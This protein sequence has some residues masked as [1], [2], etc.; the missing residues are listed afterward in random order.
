[1][2]LLAP[3]LVAAALALAPGVPAWSGVVHLVA[4]PPL[5][6]FADLRLLLSWAPSHWAFWSLAVA[7]L[8]ARIAILALLLPAGDGPSRIRFALVYYVVAWPF[9]LLAAQTSFVAHAALYSRL[10]WAA[11]VLTGA[12]GMLLAAA[13][14][15]GAATL[16]RALAVAA[17]GGFRPWPL[18]VYAV[19]LTL[20]GAAGHAGPPVVL[21]LLVPASALATLV[22]AAWLRRPAGPR[23]G[24]AALAALA[25]AA[26]VAVVVVGTRGDQ[27]VDAPSRPG[28]LMVMSGINS[29]SGEG[30][31]FEMP[32]E[33]LGY[34]C[35]Q[36]YYY[37]YAGT[38]DGQPRGDAACPIRTGAPYRPQHTQRPFDEQ[39]RFLGAQV[40]DIDGPVTVAAH[41]QA[42]W[43]A[44]EAAVRGDLPDGTSL[45]LIG[46]FPDNPVGW[47]LPGR[48]GIGR[49]GG[50]GFRLLAPLADAVDFHFIVDAPLSHEVLARPR[51][52][53]RIF[54]RPLPEGTQALSVT[55]AVDLA[56]MPHGWRIQG[57]VDT[58]P[59]REAH[60]YLPLTPALHRA[61]V[62]FLEGSP[63]PPCPPWRGG[64]VE[65][66]RAWGVPAH[67]P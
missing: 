19:A 52:G 43:V 66:S 35:A 50:D 48:D 34:Q 51:S 30:A 45:V 49:V 28:S 20:L 32:P 60:P 33:Q 26:A 44:W 1:M 3:G 21:A 54:S 63:Q 56:L 47:T 37:S 40:D 12:V 39:V 36:T 2:L 31:I 18:L 65:L 15:S 55:A 22:A 13:P 25:A 5:D 9:A 8:A 23:A 41:S 67:R 64:I 24:V 14:W 16:R 53:A 10:F 59:T 6:V 4:L 58:C 7:A 29:A 27:P 42:A 38:G 62:D 61:V 46:P 57:A 11:V 17:R